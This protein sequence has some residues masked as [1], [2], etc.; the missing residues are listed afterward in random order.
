MTAHL[1][2]DS[3]FDRISTCSRLSWL[4][5]ASLCVF[6]GGERLAHAK[7]ASV[8]AYTYE[9]I[10]PTAVRYLRVDAGFDIL[11]KDMEAGYV[12]FRLTERGK[13]YRGALEL[14]RI[15]D[16]RGR[17][18]V[19]IVVK[20]DERPSYVAKG[21]VDRIERKLR[22]DYGPPPKDPPP[23]EP[24]ADEPSDKDESSDG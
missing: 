8:T 21:I 12:L 23:P 18:R 1:F 24:P 10:W 3:R 7:A 13:T 2:R 6:L 19:R 17:K 5:I 9:Q 20:I 22:E 14:I 4:A 11:D 15:T 16:Y